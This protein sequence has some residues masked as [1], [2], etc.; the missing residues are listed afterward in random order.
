M[1]DA[2]IPKLNIPQKC[3][4]TSKTVPNRIAKTYK[5]AR[6][7]AGGRANFTFLGDGQI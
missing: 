7:M 3:K 1:K 5:E 4:N 2:I 6:I